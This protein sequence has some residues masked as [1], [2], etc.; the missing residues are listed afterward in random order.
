[1]NG[2]EDEWLYRLMEKGSIPFLSNKQMNEWTNKSM[3]DR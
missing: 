1:M 2:K 3:G